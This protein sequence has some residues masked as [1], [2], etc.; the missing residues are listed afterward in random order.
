[1]YV[2]GTGMRSTAN[3][4]PGFRRI[5]TPPLLIPATSPRPVP[6]VTSATCAAYNSSFIVFSSPSSSFSAS[7][8]LTAPA[9][10]APRPPPTGYAQPGLD[11]HRPVGQQPDD[12]VRGR[13]LGGLAVQEYFRAI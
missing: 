13:R 11:A 10:L 7:A 8:V 1:M 4:T 9:A 6:L 2:C 5:S 3:G 12:G